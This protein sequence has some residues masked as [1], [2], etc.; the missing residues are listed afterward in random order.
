MDATPPR[1]ALLSFCVACSVT[2]VGR[3]PSPLAR[4]A[5]CTLDCLYPVECSDAI[6]ARRGYG[7]SSARWNARLRYVLMVWVWVWVWRGG[8]WVGGCS[9][10]GGGG[11][12]VREVGAGSSRLSMGKVGRSRRPAPPNSGSQGARVVRCLRAP[13]GTIDLLCIRCRLSRQAGPLLPP[14]STSSFLHL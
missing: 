8:R 6:G 11:G 5:P 13:C 10:G 2:C 14:T 4:P 7:P 3:L 9:G 1:L 12:K